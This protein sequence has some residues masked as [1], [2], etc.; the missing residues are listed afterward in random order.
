MLHAMSGQTHSTL[1]PTPNKIIQ[2]GLEMNPQLSPPTYGST[3]PIKRFDNQGER[4]TFSLR[5]RFF[6]F[7]T[8]VV[9][10]LIVG[11]II[12]GAMG[13]TLA[14][15]NYIGLSTPPAYERREGAQT[16]SCSG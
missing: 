3:E 13:G 16:I 1:E 10:F 2:S 4:K 15:W 6:I 12:G 14:S 8:A 9:T 7:A 5:K 11:A